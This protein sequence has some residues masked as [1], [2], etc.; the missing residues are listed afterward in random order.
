[1][2]LF[3][4]V[5]IKKRVAP[6]IIIFFFSLTAF[7]Q[8]KITG[9][10]R[11]GNSLPLPGVTVTN[12]NT[13]KITL[14]SSDGGF[15]IDAGKGDKLEF[16]FIGYKTTEINVGNEP[17]I[18]LSLPLLGIN[19]DEVVVTGYT[20]QRIKEITGSVAIVKTKDLVA[21]PEGQLEQMLQGR[22]AGLTVISSGE[23]GTPVNV[24]LHGIGNF[25]DVT[26]LYIV[27]GLEMKNINNLNPYDIE[28]IQ[29]LKDA[30]TYS[31][32]G[33]RGANGV[34]V[35]TTKKGKPGKTRISYDFY[36]GRQIP[37]KKGLDLLNP[38]EQADLVWT[39]LKN[40]NDTA[41][42]GYPSDPLYGN[43][44][45]AVLPDY[46]IPYGA[47][48][49]DPGTDPALYD[50]SPDKPDNYQIAR[51]DKTGTD[52]FHKMFSPATSKNHT[53][54][55][56]GAN[57]NNHYLLSFGYLDQQGTFLNDYL[58][59]FTARVN[60]QFSVFKSFRVGENLQ[61]NSSVNPKLWNNGNY[62]A[63]GATTLLFNPFVPENDIK[64][65]MLPGTPI[66]IATLLND[67]KANYWEVFGNAYAEIDFL[68]KFTFRSSLGGTLNNYYSYSHVYGGYTQGSFNYNSIFNESSGYAKTWTW[69][70]TVNFSSSF[71]QNHHVKVL[72]GT[73]EKSNYNR[74]V[75]G[76]R[77]GYFTN[78]PR[79]FTLSS[80]SPTGQ[81]NYSFASSSYLNSLFSQVEYNYNEKYFLS[82]TLRRDAS[83]VFGPDSRT[84]W[85]PAVN[86]AWRITEEKFITSG[87]W[88]TEL[89]LRGSWG[90]TGFYGNTNPL[91]Q[92]TLYGGGPGSSYYDINGVSTG[93]IQPGF[94]VVRIGNSNTGWQQDIVANAGL[95]AIFWNGK[96]RLSTDVYRRNSKGLLFPA[97][98]PAYLG[99]DATIPNV[100]VGDVKN[101]GIDVLLGSKGKFSKSWN[102][103]MSLT[104]STYQ[105]KIVKLDGLP[106]L[107][108]VFQTTGGLVRNEVGYP[109]GSFFGYKIIGF[110]NDADD[111]AKSPK[112]TDAAPGRFKYLDADKDGT[113]TEADRI[114]Y[115]NPNPKF[116]L[117]FNIGINYRNFDFSTF[118]YG[119]FGNDVLNDISFV[120]DI[121]SS[122]LFLTVKSK[123]ALYNSWTPTHQNAKAPIM[124]NDVNFSNAAAINSYRL[125]K[126]TYVKNKSMILGYTFPKRWLEKIK[127][128]RFRVYIQVANLFTITKYS[129]LDPELP[130]LAPGN[131]GYSSFGIDYGN[132]PNN[133]RQYLFG[134]NLGL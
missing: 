71:L 98:L 120:T 38:Q 72:V 46:F 108:D 70:N 48:E 47:H 64:G 76:S 3:K 73:E 11:D 93:A 28:S 41:D 61:L 75:G 18:N 31:I 5:D 81:T 130:I 50:Y 129:G 55:V 100:N 90:K 56:S 122:Q 97:Q 110:F 67:D 15:D 94:R 125:E 26:P 1:M 62:S 19:L 95:D 105:N 74:E 86:V 112:Q 24:R 52:W 117:G 43:G 22:V 80:G 103:D 109:I 66:Q 29:V 102:W 45:T 121:F 87:K 123:T 16:S 57:D 104:F 79:Y 42:N 82:G 107:D 58:K 34:I 53:V 133:Q 14:T 114:H 59:R 7:A 51:F 115:G 69:T 88:L 36:I 96:L 83:S 111:V 124:E 30:G 101:S 44:P 4:K 99:A 132:Y 63:V 35:I 25:G 65:N 85:F 134:F 33:V 127:I 10:I 49:G 27:D 77:K 12:K 119:C 8:Q 13:G 126:G 9:I 68:K 40:S 89:K 106:F 39:A 37:L 32:Y 54:T 113:I 78:D 131:T 17:T 128:E 116:T 6:A 2:R 84:G 20:S 21:V 60:T 23:P 91:N 118:L 92:Y